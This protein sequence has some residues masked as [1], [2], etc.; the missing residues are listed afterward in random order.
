MDNISL[1]VTS[2]YKSLQEGFEWNNIPPFAVITGVNGVGKTQLLEVIKGRSE[3]P[4]NRGIIPQINR[5]ITSAAGLENLIFSESTTQRGLTL[6]GLVEYVQ[7]SDQRLVT[8]RNLEK[9]IN[10][11]NLY[12]NI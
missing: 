4:D 5:E 9:N 10:L 1:K 11:L 7:N 2:R 6:N 8:I 3:R 12:Q